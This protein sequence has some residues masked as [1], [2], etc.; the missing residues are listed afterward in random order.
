MVGMFRWRQFRPDQVLVD[1]PELAV[2]LGH[3]VGEDTSP[4]R[5]GEGSCSQGQLRGVS[6]HPARIGIAGAADHCEAA[7]AP[8]WWGKFMVLYCARF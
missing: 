7:H 3:A 6:P 4:R 2:D 8:D 1:L 5:S